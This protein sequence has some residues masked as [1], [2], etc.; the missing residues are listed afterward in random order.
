M[1]SLACFQWCIQVLFVAFDFGSVATVG[2][3]FVS[4]DFSGSSC[5]VF[6]VGGFVSSELVLISPLSMSLF[7]PCQDNA[8]EFLWI[9]V[10][11][12]P[13]GLCSNLSCRHRIGAKCHIS[14]QIQILSA[15]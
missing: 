5:K 14:G 9:V 15:L 4:P 8:S 10:V 3:S 2:C 1:S 11:P 6:V 13:V 12:E 7:L